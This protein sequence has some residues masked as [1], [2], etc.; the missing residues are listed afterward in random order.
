[1]GFEDFNAY[2]ISVGD[3]ELQRMMREIGYSGSLARIGQL[4]RP[5]LRKEWSFFFDCITRAFGKKSKNWDAI[6]IDSLQI[7]YSLLYGNNFDF[8]R[9]VLQNIGEKMSENRSVVY[10][11]LFC[12]LVF[13]ACVPGI[14]IAEDDVIPSFKLHKRIFSDLTNKD[15]KKGNVGDLLLP[16]IVQQFLNPPQP[17]PQPQ[18]TSQRPKSGGRTKHRAFK[19][20]KVAKPHSDAELPKSVGTS[21]IKKR[22]NIPHSDADEPLQTKRRKLVVDYSFDELVQ[23][24]TNSDAPEIIS[25]DATVPDEARANTDEMVEMNTEQ[26]EPLEMEIEENIE[27]HPSATLEEFNSADEI[28]DVATDQPTVILDESMATH[29]EVCSVT[30]QVLEKGEEVD[31]T[32]KAVSSENILEDAAE[33]VQEAAVEPIIEAD[34]ANE[35][36]FENL[37]SEDIENEAAQENVA[38]NVPKSL[39]AESLAK[40]DDIADSSSSPRVSV[41]QNPK[42]FGGTSHHDAETHYQDMYFA[43]WSSHECIFPDQRAADFVTKSATNITN[44]ELLK[45]LKAT[46]VQVKSLHNRFDDAQKVVTGLRNEVAAREMSLK[47]DKSLY[48]SLF[49]DQESFR[50]RLSKVEDNQLVMSDKLYTIAASL[51][52][53]TSVLI[54]DDVKKGERV[55]KDIRSKVS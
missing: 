30:H 9:L 54:P 21:R 8:S 39:S 51:E 47:Q 12:Q 48:V 5:L 13:S 29:T 19:A 52:L 20:I 33:T 55:F 17:H 43:N 11:A 35:K 27:A 38:E 31:Q 23:E 7:R 25:K 45:H 15:V 41:Q 40:S 37:N 24:S 53:L 4:K 42:E 34:Q 14:E 46:I 16:V 32:T 50:N 1:M 36:V 10:F 49:K 2:T 22:A 44:P 26:P 18:S 28:E 6:P 3:A